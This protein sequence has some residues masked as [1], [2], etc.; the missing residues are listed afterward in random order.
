MENLLPYEDLKARCDD[1]QSQII[2]FLKVEQELINTRSR[3]DLDLSRFRLIQDYNQKVL[4]AESIDDFA[5][6]TVESIVETFEVECSALFL[7]NK[8]ND[9]LATQ[10]L[11]RL[12]FT[13][14]LHAGPG[15]DRYERLP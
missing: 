12:R 7:Y 9:S 5:T 8:Q 6:I 4:A 14:K 2:R 15:V 11:L 3:L 10:K 13:Y 1:F